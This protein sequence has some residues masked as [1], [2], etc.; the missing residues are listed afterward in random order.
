MSQLPFANRRQAG[1][2]LA[3]SLEN[4]R[5]PRVLVLALPRGGVP[6]G[7]EVAS[8][9]GAE[10]DL[11]L[12]RKLGTP[13]NPELAMG[14]I[15]AGGFRVLNSDIVE[16]LALSA[17]A[18]EAEVEREGL[19]LARRAQ[20]YRGDRPLPRIAGRILL[21]VDDG[22]AT[23]ATMRAAI[24]ALRGQGAAQIIV[25]AP[26]APSDTVAVLE[27]EADEVICLATPEPFGAIGRF[28]QDFT[29][30]S[31]HEVRD[32]LA[33]AWHHEPAAAKHGGKS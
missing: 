9:L 22:I 13:G 26:V 1:K 3:N 31:D 17:D 7:Y 24:A 33:R 28:Y 21:L 14:A 6:V 15:A 32:L 25:A 10:L 30:V 23:G 20:V 2:L 18:I 5:G 19:E 12:V 8:A 16:A 4:Y 11:L 29:Q 27:R